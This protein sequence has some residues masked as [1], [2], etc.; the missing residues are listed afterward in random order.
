MIFTVSRTAKVEVLG[1]LFDAT[2]N[3]WIVLHG[4][5]QTAAEFLVHFKNLESPSRCFLAP[6]GLSKFYIKGVSGAVGASWMTKLDR[7]DEITDYLNYLEQVVQYVFD[8]SPNATVFLLGFSQG[9]A[10]AA[11]FFARIKSEMIGGLVLWGAV[12][13]PDLQLPD[14]NQ[15]NSNLVHIV[16]GNSDPY[17][18]SQGTEANSF[19]QPRLWPFEGGHEV[20]PEILREVVLTL[21]GNG[22]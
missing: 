20:P 9:A 17:F 15:I 1:D 14:L 11:R 5:G 4:Y 6:E 19:I 3:V 22:K 16:F 8:T 7:E 12:F 2:Q 13:P 18:L 21:E 10:A